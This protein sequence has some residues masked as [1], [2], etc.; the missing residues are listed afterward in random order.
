MIEVLKCL[1]ALDHPLEAWEVDAVR[2]VLKAHRDTVTARIHMEEN[3]VVPIIMKRFR[4][5]EKV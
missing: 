3:T 2:K 1:E 5:P 4:Y